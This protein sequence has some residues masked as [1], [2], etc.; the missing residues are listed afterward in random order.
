MFNKDE[1]LVGLPLL[2]EFYKNVTT[3]WESQVVTLLESMFTGQKIVVD[4]VLRNVMTRVRDTAKSYNMKLFSRMVFL[5]MMLLEYLINL[6]HAQTKGD[7]HMTEQN[8][9]PTKEVEHFQTFIS[10][11]ANI[12][13]QDIERAV[14][15]VGVCVGILLEVQSQRYN[16]VAPFWN[17]LNRLDLEPDKMFSLFTEVKS[18]LAM[19]GEERFNTI[20]N[21]LAVNEISR[22]NI[23]S[24]ISKE[25][26]NLIFSIGLSY[27]YLL[28]RGYLI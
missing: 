9:A 18:K 28:K 23:I 2:T 1:F 7:S 10:N 4:D 25:N 5:G 13:G 12:I 24:K 15:V 3:Q 21:Y 22:R 27:G 17:R 16:K 11:H 26:L 20:I 19:Y 6:N 14:F 8:E